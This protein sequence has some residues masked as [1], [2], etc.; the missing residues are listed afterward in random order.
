M[1]SQYITFDYDYKMYIISI[2]ILNWNAAHAFTLNDMTM[3]CQCAL[4]RCSLFSLL[5]FAASAA[6]A[7]AD[8]ILVVVVDVHFPPEKP[9]RTHTYPFTCYYCIFG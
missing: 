5:L 8:D 6:A 1:S 2:G 7:A 4:F 3:H 9:N